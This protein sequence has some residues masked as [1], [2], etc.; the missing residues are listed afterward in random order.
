MADADENLQEHL[1]KCRWVRVNWSWRKVGRMNLGIFLRFNP[2]VSLLS[3]CIIWGFVTWCIVKSDEA[4][5]EMGRWKIWITE[6]F[7]WMYIGTQD[8]WAVIIIMLYFSKH[9][10]MK[11][12]RDDEEPEFNDVTYFTMLFAAGIGI[13][14]FYFGVA[15]PIYHYVP[16]VYGNRYYGRYTDNQLAQDAMNLTFFHWG[17]H[18]WIV[19][20]VVGL[21]LAFVCYRQG[22]PM[23]VR[24]CF[25]PLIGDKIYGWMGDVIDILSICGTM[26]GVCTSLGLGAI[27]LNAGIQRLNSDIEMSSTNQIIIIWCVTACAT[28]SVIT[29]LKLGIR[30][31]SEICFAIG[32]LLML[33]VFFYDETWY[34]LNLYVQSTGYYLQWIIQLG[35]HTDAFA[36]MGNSQD[37]KDVVNW[38]N[39]WTIFYWGWWIAWSPFVG[40][41]IAKISRGR[42]IKQFINATM[43]API[44]YSFMWLTIFGGAGIRLERRAFHANVTCDSILGGKTSTESF[45]GLWR[46]SCRSTDDMWFDLMDQYGDIG[47]V[48]QVVSLAGII[49]YFV[50]SS[51]SGSLVIDCL[52]ANGDPDPPI[53]QRVFW[54]LTEGATA[55]ALLF[56]GGPKAL[57]ALQTVSIAAGVPYTI[58]LC[59]MCIALWRAVHIEAG[60]L[61]PNGPSFSVDLLEPVSN[62]T[63]N[64]VTRVVVAIF[65]P[66]YPMGMAAWRLNNSRGGKLS[67]FLSHG[68]PFY[69]W[70]LGMALEPVVEGLSYLAWAILFAFFAFGTATR[71]GIREKYGINGNM[72]EDF[73]AVMLL[74]PFAAYQMDHFMDNAPMGGP[75]SLDGGYDN[76]K[77]VSYENKG[78]NNVSY[79]NKGADN[80]P[81]EKIDTSF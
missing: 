39:A 59:F 55:T 80:V 60:V 31:L 34:L 75:Y 67:Y 10:N 24:S 44:V 45:N 27:Q 72:V 62:P 4:N 74:Y 69:L 29:G 50:T 35:F 17:V 25:Y 38:M 16:G 51:D 32:M 1:K 13:G 63:L 28:V 66:W 65:F 79:E 36:Q 58:L 47:T 8:I 81:L 43:T 42:T 48:L 15:E 64:S 41:F 46:L 49:L 5:E 22:L 20:V 33:V 11:L 19:Y 70:V 56:A 54:A 12:G 3:A 26:F 73:F 30:R 77:P 57:T 68:I 53:L 40:M 21:L 6:K 52:S 7:T 14:L 18:G 61:D 78:A 71:I 9:S 76:E 37:K 23:T 2:L